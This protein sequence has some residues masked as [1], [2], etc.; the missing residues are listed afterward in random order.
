MTIILFIILG[1]HVPWNSKP[2]IFAAA[3]IPSIDLLIRLSQILTYRLHQFTLQRIHLE[4]EL[5]NIAQIYGSPEDISWDLAVISTSRPLLIEM[6]AFI[7]LTGGFRRP[8]IPLHLLWYA[9]KN[10][11]HAPL[12]NSYDKKLEHDTLPTEKKPEQQN[13]IYLLIR[14]HESLRNELFNG[15][16][17]IEGPYS[18]PLSI[19]SRYRL[20]EGISIFAYNEGILRVFPYIKS[21]SSE[22]GIISIIW[23]T[24]QLFLL[25]QIKQLVKRESI[26]QYLQNFHIIFLDRKGISDNHIFFQEFEIRKEMGDTDG[27][28]SDFSL[29]RKPIVLGAGNDIFRKRV[30][31][32]CRN[33]YR[34]A[35]SYYKD[36]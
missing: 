34:E 36:L 21:L 7:Y 9:E 11:K 33:G 31:Q 24:T 29:Y 32:N 20:Q 18:S 26:L 1:L 8:D 27:M 28:D 35:C 3:G 14:T 6:G 4:S 10:L 16:I 22:G 12:I 17:F 25:L 5:E 2:Y 19:C 15:Q 13:S 30:K 23:Y